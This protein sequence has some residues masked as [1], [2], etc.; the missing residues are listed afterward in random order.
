[1]IDMVMVR[2]VVG[3]KQL[4]TGRSFV[5]SSIVHMDS[6]NVV[7]Q[8]LVAEQL[9]LG[10]PTNGVNL[11]REY[12]SEPLPEIR[13]RV[14]TGG[15]L[16]TELVNRDVGASAAFTGFLCDVFRKAD[17]RYQDEVNTSLVLGSNIHYPVEVNA[18]DVLVR[19]DTYGRSLLGFHTEC[20]SLTGEPEWR[21]AA[22]DVLFAADEVQH[23][24]C[25][26]GSLESQDFTR[27]V[28]MISTVLARMG[29]NPDDFDAYR[30]RLEY[31]VMPSSV[32]IR[33]GLPE[34]PV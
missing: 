4:R 34:R 16:I 21:D 5:I 31:P 11:L 28:D 19:R 20:R 30:H 26:T 10:E 7:D 17:T 2:G 1:M 8:R 24:G 9:G 15:R 13:N 23:L 12:C 27:Y 32:V 18:T 33:G 3:L 6:N 14:T 29:W 22:H 25:G